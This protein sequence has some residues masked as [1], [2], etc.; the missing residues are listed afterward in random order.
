MKIDP[1]PLRCPLIMRPILCRAR[2]RWG[3]G[4]RQ[5]CVAS[6]GKKYAMRLVLWPTQSRARVRDRD[7]DVGDGNTSG[8][9]R[10]RCSPGDVRYELS[11]PYA[12]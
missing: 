7:R 5:R 4:S 6:Y 2:R 8:V 1:A 3:D 11:K 12:S 9:A 10:I